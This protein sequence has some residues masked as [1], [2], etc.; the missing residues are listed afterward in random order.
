M[1]DVN[2]PLQTIR[3]QIVRNNLK[4]D[5]HYC[6]GHSSQLVSIDNIVVG[7]LIQLS[8][9]QECLTPSV[10]IELVN[11]LFEGQPIQKHLIEWKK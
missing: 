10:A 3:Q 5:N 2:I 8:P 4:N 7:I 11:S 9:I 1:T 6:V